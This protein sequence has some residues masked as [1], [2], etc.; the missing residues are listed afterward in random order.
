MFEYLD[1]A[2]AAFPETRRM[3]S[4]VNKLLLL[5]FHAVKRATAVVSFILNT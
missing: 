2:P 3:Q 5:C 1:V 4:Y